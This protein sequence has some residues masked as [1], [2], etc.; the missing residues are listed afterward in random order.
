MKWFKHLVN[1]TSD[2]NLM[3]AEL[4]FKANG[5]YVFWRVLEILAR[6]DILVKP[7]IMNFKVFKSWFPAISSKKLKDI[8]QFFCDKKRISVEYINGDIKIFCK[9]LSVISSNYTKKVQRDYEES[10]NSERSLDIEV[11]LEKD[12]DNKQKLSP[13][14]GLFNRESLKELIR[15]KANGTGWKT[16]CKNINEKF[17]KDYES[18]KWMIENETDKELIKIKTFLEGK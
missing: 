10:T 18:L 12:K 8:L 9:K 5:T 7:L 4:K 16:L 13:D 2:P 3:E 17:G 1:S 11:D 14:G 6:E 15:E